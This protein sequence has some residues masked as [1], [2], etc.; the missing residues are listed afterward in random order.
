M[1]SPT[2]TRCPGVA[3]SPLILTCPPA[4][5]AVARLRVLKNRQKYNHRSIRKVSDDA[6]MTIE[7][8]DTRNV[9]GSD[10]PNCLITKD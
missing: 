1:Q 5:A 6:D 7:V 3:R 4:T 2:L 8:Y 9:P 10:L